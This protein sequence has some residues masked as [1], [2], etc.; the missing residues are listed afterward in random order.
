MTRALKYNIK[1]YFT[2]LGAVQ[3]S[4]EVAFFNFSCMEPW[5]QRQKGQ[6]LN[7]KKQH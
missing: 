4:T 3:R 6:K 7:P 2:D 5:S 1:G